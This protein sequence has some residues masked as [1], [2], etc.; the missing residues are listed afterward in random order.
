MPQPYCP[1]AAFNCSSVPPPHTTRASPPVPGTEP[2]I[3]P[4]GRLGAETEPELTG[5]ALGGGGG[6]GAPSPSGTT[7]IAATQPISLLWITSCQSNPSAEAKPSATCTRVPWSRQR[8]GFPF[9]P[10]SSRKRRQSPSALITAV[11]SGASCCGCD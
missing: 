3:V 10:G 8:I 11:V 7:Y 4:T 9:T 1:A 6:G 2:V 5:A